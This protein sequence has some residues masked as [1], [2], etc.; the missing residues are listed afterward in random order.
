MHRSSHE[1]DDSTSAPRDRFGE[2]V[3][4]NLSAESIQA[5][6]IESESRLLARTFDE[7][8][9]SGDVPRAAS[10]ILG[11]RRRYI[12]G[13]G[14]ASAYAHLLGT[15]LSSTLSNVFLIDGRALTPL[16]VLTDVRNTDVLVVFSLRKYREETIRLAHLFVEAG[17]QLVVVTDSDDAPLTGIATVAIRVRTASASYADSTIAVAAVCHL[18][19]TLTAASA[20]GA[21]RRLAMRDHYAL[22]LGLYPRQKA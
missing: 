1:F 20:K 17:G 14:K 3:R 19:S 21:K 11:G 8:V 15:D 9:A 7:L 4:K 18:L 6:V 22:E 5:S 2:R 10:L 16:T 12:A 13:E